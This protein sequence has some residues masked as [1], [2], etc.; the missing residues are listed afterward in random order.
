VLWFF[1]SSSVKSDLLLPR[2]FDVYWPRHDAAT[3]A[4]ERS[5][6]VLVCLA[7]LSLA[8][9]LAVARHAWRR[10]RRRFLHR[11]PRRSRRA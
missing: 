11:S 4:W 10:A 3:P 6:D 1:H 5:L 8:N 2:N 9:W 7:P